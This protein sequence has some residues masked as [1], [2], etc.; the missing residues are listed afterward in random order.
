MKIWEEGGGVRLFYF[1]ETN[2]I[3]PEV[4]DRTE[5]ID[6]DKRG[7]RPDGFCV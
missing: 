2:E 6:I 1:G 7:W 5:T 3:E 4:F